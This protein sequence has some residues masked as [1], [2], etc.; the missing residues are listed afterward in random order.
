MVRPSVVATVPLHSDQAF[1]EFGSSGNVAQFKGKVVQPGG[2]AKSG[3]RKKALAQAKRIEGALPEGA[4]RPVRRMADAVGVTDVLTADSSTGLDP[5][6]SKDMNALLGAAMSGDALAFRAGCRDLDNRFVPSDSERVTRE[7]ASAFLDHADRGGDG[8]IRLSWWSKPYP[9]NFGDWLSPMIV[10]SRCGANIRL[11]PVTKATKHTHLFAVGSIGRFIRASSI[12]V[13]TGV[14]RTDLEVSRKARYV[15][16]RGPLTAAVVR[17]SGGPRVDRFGDPAVLLSRV[18]PVERGHTNGRVALVRHFS[19]V[20][21]P[22]RL[23]DHVDELSVLMSRPSG[24]Q[25]FLHTLN[26]YDAVLTSTLHVMIACQSYGIPGGLITFR[27]F[28]SRIHGQGMKYEDYALG[29]GVQVLNPRV[30]DLDLR[31]RELDALIDD[32]RID[33]AKKDEVETHL[34]TAIELLPRGGRRGSSK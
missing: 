7:V 9:G 17:E 31:G 30:V 33:E 15:S 24:I 27:G 19:H 1:F 29:A 32:V 13:G 21:V 5:Q 4:R 20:D 23:P 22:I 26:S 34:A 8:H 18:V 25:A 3:P 14:S 28:G 2:K 10:A 12:V 16:V 6:R 11:Q